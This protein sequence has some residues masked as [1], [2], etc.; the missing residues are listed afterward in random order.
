MG[1]V[2]N[3]GKG[4]VQPTK[5]V[6]CVS[7][8]FV[9]TAAVELYK[10]KVDVEK[11][12]IEQL[13]KQISVMKKKILEQVSVCLSVHVCPCLSAVFVCLCSVAVVTA[14]LRLRRGVCSGNPWVASTRQKT[15]KPWSTSKSACWRTGWTRSVAAIFFIFFSSRFF[16]ETTCPPAL[17]CYSSRQALVKFNEALATNK[18]LRKQIDDLRQERVVFDNIYKKLEKSLVTKK[19]SMAA[20]IEASNEAYEARDSA[21]MEIAALQHSMNRER[22]EFEEAM[23]SLTRCG[24]VWWCVELVV[25]RAPALVPFLSPLSSLTLLPGASFGGAAGKSSQAKAP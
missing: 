18:D 8:S 2:V 13:S 20:I 24:M 22:Q 17:C 9:R 3:R 16:F 4:P 11:R 7:F 23:L 14:G 1:C 19:K 15:T 5:F 21:Q 10:T 12:N 25:H 6:V